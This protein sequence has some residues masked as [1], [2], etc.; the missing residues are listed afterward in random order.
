MICRHCS[1]FKANRPRGL[2]WKCYYTPGVR[3]LFPSTSKFVGKK[4]PTQAELDA[5]IAEQMKCL[6][7]WWDKE[8]DTNKE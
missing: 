3:D 5:T 8:S 7:E 1:K 4:E 6:P 2:C